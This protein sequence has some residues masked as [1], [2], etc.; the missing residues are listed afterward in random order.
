MQRL[1]GRAFGGEGLLTTRVREQ[2]FGVLLLDKFEK[3]H[4]LRGM[5]NLHHCPTDLV[6]A[7]RFWEE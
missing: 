2:P 4:P 5:D 7:L 1:T 6:P 3:A